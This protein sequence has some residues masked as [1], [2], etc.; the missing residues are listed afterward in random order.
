V[1]IL[2]IGLNGAVCREIRPLD[3]TAGQLRA[4]ERNLL[5]IFAGI[6]SAPRV[7]TNEERPYVSQAKVGAKRE[8][9]RTWKGRIH[10]RG[11]VECRGLSASRLTADGNIGADLH[12]DKWK[13]YSAAR[14]G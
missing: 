9:W 4:R 10:K 12:A 13:R 14:R 1:S 6:I 11:A 2:Q 3:V 5:A 8:R 7:H